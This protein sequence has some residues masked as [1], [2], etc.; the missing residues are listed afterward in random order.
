MKQEDLRLTGS[1]DVARG[2]YTLTYP[3]L[4]SRRFQVRDGSI[5]F[6][7]T[8]GVDPNLSITA[9]YR[10]RDSYGEPLDIL[11][12]VS[13]TLQS[14][15]VRLSSDAQQPISE[16]DL[17]SYLFFGRPTWQVSSVTS[18]T[19]SRDAAADLGMSVLAPSVLGYA[20]SGL[21]TLVQSA[22]LLDYVALTAADGAQSTESRS[23][24]IANF[25]TGTKLEVGR[26][27]GS[28]LYVGYSQMLSTASLEPV[29]R[30]E[31]QFLPEYSL[32]LF[33]EDRLARTPGFGLRPE[34]GLRR[35]YGFLLF[36]EWGF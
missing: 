29:M 1:L 33:A 27:F 5:E 2:T 23:F 8:P 3:P 12:V 22:G 34:T 35:V 36:R 31:W 20:S 7:G 17:A 25:L 15:R 9:A 6:L 14:P 21:Q 16:S 24:G 18:A 28:D 32:E 11:A 4:Q 10:A 13:G 30:L 26:Y 19:D